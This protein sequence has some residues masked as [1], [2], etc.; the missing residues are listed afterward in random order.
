VTGFVPVARLDALAPGTLMEVE[1][2]GQSVCLARTE[3]GEVYAFRNNCSHR[4]FP[5]HTGELEGNQLECAWHG[6]RFDVR[7]GRALRLPAIKPIRAYTVKIEDG[8]ILVDR[9]E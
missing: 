1:V 5:L 8:E 4:D 7:T 6:A 2:D 3:D 9:E